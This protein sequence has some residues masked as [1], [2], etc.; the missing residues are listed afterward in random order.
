MLMHRPRTPQPGFG[1][2]TL[3]QKFTPLFKILDPRLI[4]IYVTELEDARTPLNAKCIGNIQRSLASLKLMRNK[5]LATLLNRL[6]CKSY[7]QVGAGFAK[8]RPAAQRPAAKRLATARRP[9]AQS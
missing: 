2:I 6:L 1:S 4:N 8:S 9:G 3:L 5:G 7:V